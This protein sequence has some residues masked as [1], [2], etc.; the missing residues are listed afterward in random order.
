MVFLLTRRPKNK[1]I[2]PIVPSQGSNTKWRALHSLITKINESVGAGFLNLNWSNGDEDEQFN[3][4]TIITVFDWGFDKK[5][6][7]SQGDTHQISFKFCL[8]VF[9]IITSIFHEYYFN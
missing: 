6:Y 3:S 7:D 2:Y 1:F 4:I 8:G 5:G 9:N